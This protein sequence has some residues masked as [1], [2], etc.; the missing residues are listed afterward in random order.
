MEPTHNQEGVYCSC[1]PVAHPALY[2][3][4]VGS[5]TL[6]SDDNSEIWGFAINLAAILFAKGITEG[7]FQEERKM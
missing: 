4:L 3:T 2:T 6:P 5:L 1:G 7:Q